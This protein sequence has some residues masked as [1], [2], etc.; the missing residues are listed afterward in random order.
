MRLKLIVGLTLCVLGV[1][2][3]VVSN[4]AWN[5]S[6]NAKDDYRA[7]TEELENSENEGAKENMK[8]ERD[9]AWDSWDASQK[10]A[11]L[12]SAVT[13]IFAVLGV[14]LILLDVMK[15]RIPE[16]ENDEKV[17]EEKILEEKSNKSDLE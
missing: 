12:A 7:I 17:I 10:A 5:I 4:Y 15:I 16:E 14:I 3:V 8:K 13:V 6:F 1:I 11:A 2:G 9:K